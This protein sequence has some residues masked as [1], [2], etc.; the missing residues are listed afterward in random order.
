MS[1]KLPLRAVI[2]L[3]CLFSPLTA[4]DIITLRSGEKIEGK[5]LEVTRNDVKFETKVHNIRT[6]VTYR[7]AQVADIEYKELPADFWGPGRETPP[8]TTQPQTPPPQPEQP[9]T[10]KPEGVEAP[11][12]AE[13]DDEPIE[14]PTRRGRRVDPA[15]QYVVVPVKG[16]IGVEVTAH[17]LRA[18]LLQTKGRGVKHVVFTVDSPGGYVFEAVQILE[19][20][21]EFD[22]D[23]TYHCL[24]ESG[25]ISAA[26]VFAAGADRIYVRPGARLGGAVAYTS[27]NSTGATEVDAKFN[28]IWSAE[29]AS[30]AE[31]KGHNGDAFRAMIIM[32]NQLWQ[33]DADGSLSSRSRGPQDTQIDG[34]NT[35]LTISA[36]QMVRGGMATMVETPIDSMGA[37]TGVEDW[38]ELRTIGQRAML[39]AARD[40][41]DMKRRFDA[42]IEG[43]N[44]AIGELDQNHPS[45]GRYTIERSATGTLSMQS[46]SMRE[47]QS[48]TDAAV[49]ACN[50]MLACLKE[51]ASINSRAEKSGAQHL[52]I[53]SKLGHERYVE[54]DAERSKLLNQR[55]RPPVAEMLQP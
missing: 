41:A 37:M 12:N 8:N 34:P 24:I 52:L 21:K 33:S 23:L 43:F 31:S 22:T 42:A 10:T 19:T 50:I 16:T 3:L 7:R 27:D 13:P 54:I 39:T 4:A 49:R 9:E 55:N 46:S 30:R 44:K 29:V 45:K 2:L 20:L 14:E 18:A 36:A 1:M 28:S 15:S 6:T 5:V 40:R 51:L 48:R 53:P 11:D 38:A 35:V 47:W 32:A 25:A 26:S 17:G